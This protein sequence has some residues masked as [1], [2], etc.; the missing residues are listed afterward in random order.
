MCYEYVNYIPKKI[1]F[2]KVFQLKKKKKN[3]EK[4]SKSNKTAFHF[5]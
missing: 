1:H 2:E 5:K 4:L 3:V